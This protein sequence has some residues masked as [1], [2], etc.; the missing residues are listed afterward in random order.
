MSE[1]FRF[2]VAMLIWLVG[3]S[4]MGI[5]LNQLWP[6]GLGAIIGVLS[7]GVI[8]ILVYFFLPRSGE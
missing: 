5:G 2:F 4:A 3:A 1:D 8:A 7:G 6:N